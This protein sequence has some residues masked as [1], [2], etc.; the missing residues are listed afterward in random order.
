MLREEYNKENSQQQDLDHVG[1]G[2]EESQA[3]SLLRTTLFV[4][5][6][7]VRIECF[8]PGDNCR[9]RRIPLIYTSLTNYRHLATTNDF[10]SYRVSET[11]GKV[12]QHYL[13]KIIFYTVPCYR[14]Y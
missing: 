8:W 2:E 11:V 5:V 10:S 7:V 6:I 9:W 13:Y 4:A 1:V 3:V 14:H 12:T